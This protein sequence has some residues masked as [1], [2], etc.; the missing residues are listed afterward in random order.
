MKRNTHSYFN[1]TPI[2][3]L[4]FLQYKNKMKT[5]GLKMRFKAFISLVFILALFTK[6]DKNN[7]TTNFNR[8]GDCVQISLSTKDIDQSLSFYK[9]LGFKE[10]NERRNSTVPWALVSDGMFMFMISQHD[11]PSPTLIYYGEN[12]AKRIQILRSRGVSFDTIFNDAKGNTTAITTDP[13]QL[14]ITIINFNT[15]KLPTPYGNS[16]CILGQFKEVII[17]TDNLE[18]STNFWQKVGFSKKDI[19]N[20]PYLN[21]TLTDGLIRIGLHKNKKYINFTFSYVTEN[22]DQVINRLKE[23]DII[24]KVESTDDGRITGIFLKSPDNQLFYV[25]EIS[26]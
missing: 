7:G 24:K 3:I 4:K 20:I 26:S 25:K 15:N 21:V 9:K 6:C 16:Y 17:P 2:L 18:N 10:I 13:N 12:S 11:F 5:I 23:M 22:I 1:H 8:L 14:N 19:N